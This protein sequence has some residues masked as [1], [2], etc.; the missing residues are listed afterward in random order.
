MWTEED[1]KLVNRYEFKD[2]KQAISFINEIAKICNSVNHHPEIYNCYNQVKLYLY[3]HDSQDNITQKD[4]Q[5]GK[6]IDK[7]ICKMNN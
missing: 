5:L 4:Y 7:V 1:G 3:T 6:L 2:F